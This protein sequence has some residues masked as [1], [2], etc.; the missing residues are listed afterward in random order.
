M[1]CVL[2]YLGAEADENTN[3]LAAVQAAVIVPAAPVRSLS[4]WP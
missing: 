4:P 2:E 1:S 3:R